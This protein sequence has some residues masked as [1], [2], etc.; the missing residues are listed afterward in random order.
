M[1]AA[2]E[3]YRRAIESLEK[4]PDAP[5]E[6]LYDALVGWVQAA[7]RFSR[8]ED[9]LAQAERAVNIARSMGDK[10]RLVEGASVSRARAG[11]YQEL[12]FQSCQPLEQRFV[13]RQRDVVEEGVAAIDEPRDAALG[14]M[15]HQPVV[16]GEIDRPRRI[17]L[18]R[19]RRHG[20]H[21]VEIQRF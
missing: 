9:T 18:P 12:G 4:L 7:F 14:H 13:V 10:R 15:T 1:R 3:H 6:K 21:A 19:Q 11:N 20:K 8:Y 2:I 17:V 5:P 16:L